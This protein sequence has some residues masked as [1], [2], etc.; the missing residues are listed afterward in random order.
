M[1]RMLIVEK[2]LAVRLALQVRLHSAPAIE[3]EASVASPADAEMLLQTMSPDV[4]LIGLASGRVRDL[5]PT[6]QAI[7]S[8]VARG[9][10][11]IVLTSFAD[12]MERE[13]TLEA[14]ASCYLLKQIDSTKLIAGIEHLVKAPVS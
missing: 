5:E 11:V 9:I 8:F 2:H 12:D 6:I 1:I 3:V 14:G 7:S 13:L 10:Q 4:A